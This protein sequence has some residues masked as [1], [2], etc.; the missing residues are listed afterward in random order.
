MQ[1]AGWTQLAAARREGREGAEGVSVTEQD[2]ELKQTRKSYDRGARRYADTHEGSNNVIQHLKRFLNYCKGT[3]I[4]DVGCGP[5]HEIAWFC[6]SGKK[7]YGIDSS[8]T[9]LKMAKNRAPKA[10]LMCLDMKDFWTLN[11]TFDGIWVCSSFYHLPKRYASNVLCEM[12]RALT[13]AGHM[14]LAV[15]EGK[16]ERFVRSKNTNGR[17]KWYAFY[18]EEEMGALLEYCGFTIASFQKEKKRSVWLNYYLRKATTVRLSFA[19][20]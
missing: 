5:G 7:V 4:L 3:R 15:K 1:G 19:R 20:W 17:P 16:G 10:R 9:M 6:E 14:Y 12:A 13:P 18:E 2:L 8:F 11:G